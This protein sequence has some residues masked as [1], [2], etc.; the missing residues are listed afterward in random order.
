VLKSLQKLEISDPKE[1]CGVQSVKEG[2]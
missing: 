1:A 2:I